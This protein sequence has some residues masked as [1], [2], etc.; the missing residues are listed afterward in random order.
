M[1]IAAYE[2]HQIGFWDSQLAQNNA[3]IFGAFGLRNS[4]KSFDAG[5]FALDLLL[6]HL[7][8]VIYVSSSCDQLNVVFEGL[9]VALE[10][11]IHVLRNF[12]VADHWPGPVQNINNHL[13]VDVL[14]LNP[15]ELVAAFDGIGVQLKLG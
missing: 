15:N 10:Q 5:V 2:A 13:L 3:D 4:P 14:Q 1:V 11:L 9:G 8:H 7:D 6:D 12:V